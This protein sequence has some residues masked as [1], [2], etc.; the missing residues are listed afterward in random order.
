MIC[1]SQW[2]CLRQIA[3]FKAVNLINRTQISG[4]GRASSP[5]GEEHV[6]DEL[7]TGCNCSIV[8]V[9]DNPGSLEYLAAALAGTGLMIFTAASGEA[10]LALIYTHRPQIVLSDLLMPTMSGLDLLRLV[11]E[12]DPKTSVVI[13]SSNDPDRAMAK[14][15]EQTGT[16]YLKK[17]IA[18]SVLRSCIGQLIQ[19]HFVRS[20]D[21]PGQNGAGSSPSR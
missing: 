13:M 17:P 19:N 18:L 2:R 7:Q 16:E 6:P 4:Q 5:V 9:D 21:R 20:Q 12:F 10:G 1:R 15:L 8:I 14:T 3:Q 11:K